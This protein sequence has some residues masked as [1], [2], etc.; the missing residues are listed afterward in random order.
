[1]GTTDHCNGNRGANEDKTGISHVIVADC[2]SVV[3]SERTTPWRV[4]PK[5][6]AANVWTNNQGK[7]L[8]KCV[9]E[10]SSLMTRFDRLVV[11]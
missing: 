6:L 1:M 5:P 4:G 9:E 7:K 10:P 8:E 3:H 11:E 2:E